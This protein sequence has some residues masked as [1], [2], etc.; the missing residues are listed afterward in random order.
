MIMILILLDNCY[1]YKNNYLDCIYS[2][3]FMAIANVI[4]NVI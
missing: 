3:R 2:N 1:N 4:Y